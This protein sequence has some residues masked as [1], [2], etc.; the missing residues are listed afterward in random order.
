MDKLRVWD[1][2][3]EEPVNFDGARPL[4]GLFPEIG[5]SHTVFHLRDHLCNPTEVLRLVHAEEKENLRIFEFVE[6]L[7]VHGL[8]V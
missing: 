1:I 2:L 4:V 6:S 7:W 8:R 3:D 5:V